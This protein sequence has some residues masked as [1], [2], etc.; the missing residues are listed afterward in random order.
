MKIP[1]DTVTFVQDVRGPGDKM[2]AHM[3]KTFVSMAIAAA[4]KAD[5]IARKRDH[6]PDP[7]ACEVTYD[8]DL[9]AV[10]LQRASSVRDLVLVPWVQVLSAEVS[11]EKLTAPGGRK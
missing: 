4:K 6:V 9:G 3:G 1:L 8:T 7:K 5:D 2:T 10:L 11:L